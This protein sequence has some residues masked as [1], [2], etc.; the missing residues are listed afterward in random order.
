MGEPLRAAGMTDQAIMEAVYAAAVL[1]V[2][3]RVVTSLGARKASPG[4][5]DSTAAALLKRGYD[6]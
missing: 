2:A 1:S 4:Q 3:N 5:R 6:L